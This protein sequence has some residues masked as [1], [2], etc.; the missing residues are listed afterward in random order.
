MITPAAWS[1]QAS[2]AGADGLSDGFRLAG[3]AGLAARM[4]S[5]QEKP[6]ARKAVGPCDDREWFEWGC[7]WGLSFSRLAG[8]VRTAV[9]MKIDLLD[10]LRKY[11]TA[12]GPKRP[13]LVEKQ[14]YFQGFERFSNVRVG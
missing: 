5:E 10:A 11:G 7:S 4:P 13:V 8:T 6:V 1:N 9:W 12:G 2:G 3:E 14:L